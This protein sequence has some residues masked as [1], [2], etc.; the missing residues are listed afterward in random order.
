L[1]TT[2]ER[3]L[4]VLPCAKRVRVVF[5]GQTIADS[6]AVL[7]LRGKGSLPVYYFPRAH[8]KP[9]HLRSAAEPTPDPSAG[10]IVRFALTVGE[11]RAEDAAWSFAQPA[12]LAL[13]ALKD[14]IAF[15]WKAVDAWFEEDEEVFVHARDPHVRVDTLQSSAHVQVIL[16]GTVV[17]DSRRPVVL[18][19]TGHPVRYYLPADDVRLDLLAFSPKTTRCP[20]K[21]VASYWSATIDGRT[22]EDVA[23]QYRD[24]IP[25]VLKIRDL[26]A[27]YPE[28]VDAILRDGEKVA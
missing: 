12:D 14:H 25:E 1:S 18:V 22:Y 3:T 15:A 20:Y 19:E 13:A 8:V 24:P 17:A 10:P 5:A 9:E 23:W 16:A 6:R 11:R 28:A 4:E 21:G 27:F 2:T 26:I 7:I